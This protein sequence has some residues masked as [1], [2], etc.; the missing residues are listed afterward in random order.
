MIL[1]A[2]STVFGDEEFGPENSSMFHIGQ[3]PGSKVADG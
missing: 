3:V 2:S 1:G